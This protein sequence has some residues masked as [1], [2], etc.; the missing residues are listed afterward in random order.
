M[1]E[2]LTDFQEKKN[3]CTGPKT[4][5][6]RVKKLI[7]KKRIKGQK[8]IRSL[9]RPKKNE[10]L[11]FT[12]DFND[13]CAQGGIDVDSQQLQLAIALSKSLQQSDQAETVDFPTNLTSQERTNRIRRTLQEY[14]FKIPQAKIKLET[15][16]RVK[17]YRKPFK[18]LQISEEERIQKICNKYSQVLLEN[19]DKSYENETNCCNINNK[20]YHI[21]TNIT[22]EYI[23]TNELYKT[24]IFDEISVSK[25]NLLRDWSDIPGRPVSPNLVEDYVISMQDI[26]CSQNEL[27][28]ILSGRLFAAKNILKTK[29]NSYLNTND[30]VNNIPEINITYENTKLTDKGLNELESNQGNLSTMVH[31]QNRSNSPD[32]FDDDP[33]IINHS[34]SENQD[35][36]KESTKTSDVSILNLTPTVTNKEVSSQSLDNI[37]KRKSNDFMDLTECVPIISNCKTKL[38]ETI[39]EIELAHNSM[40]FTKCVNPISQESNI[41]K[42]QIINFFSIQECVTLDEDSISN[43][44]A[45]VSGKVLDYSSDDTIIL[46]DDFID[47]TQNCGPKVLV[48]D[49]LKDDMEIMD[50]TQSSNS[51]E[52]PAVNI[53]GT[54]RLSPDD[55]IILPYGSDAMPQT[56]FKKLN[57]DVIEVNDLDISDD[58]LTEINSKAHNEP[59]INH[60]SQHL[61]EDFVAD[62]SFRSENIENAQ[63][64]GIN[65]DLTQSSHSTIDDYHENSNNNVFENLQINDYDSLGKKGDISIDYDEIAV[66]QVENIS[67]TDDESNIQSKETNFSQSPNNMNNSKNDIVSGN[68]SDFKLC[69][70]ELNYSLYK[71]KVDDDFDDISTVNDNNEVPNNQ[72]SNNISCYNNYTINRSLSESDLP[73]VNINDMTK[74]VDK[75]FNITLSKS[76]CSTPIKATITN[77]KISIKT[78][79]N[80]EYV[81][82]LGEVT[83]MLDYEAMS[84]PERNKELEKYGLK[85]FKRK[86]AIQL[87][88]HLYNQTHPVIEQC[89]E[90]VPF[91]KFKPNSPEE[92]SLEKNNIALNKENIYSET[93][94][95]PD[96]KNIECCPDD[97]IFQKREKAK[98]HSCPVPLHIAFHNY[99]SCRRH[100]REA[101]LRYEPINIDVIHK[102]LVSYGYKY[103]PKDLLKFLD[104]KCITVK[105]ADNKARNSK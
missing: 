60:N 31:E 11:T 81:V 9:I 88:T 25:G 91:K 48:E 93:K 28:I 58:I 84:S 100:L 76:A 80:S 41:N 67:S 82:K 104:R 19:P 71:S 105:T 95:I 99:V 97:W 56:N 26:Q 18:L 101:I 1:D 74:Y 27:D 29:L 40:E 85:P 64:N 86:R 103:N 10:L 90:D 47:L 24:E 57:K 8:D 37:T 33:S 32:I 94:T 6:P 39:N 63:E 7:S 55:T 92:N 102:D 15:F 12:K 17:K 13:V 68:I 22:Y 78:P 66:D 83:P 45:A 54:Q 50:L 70:R 38:L 46:K 35:A 98:V 42:E 73:N 79:T 62:Q 72:K 30:Q 59:T 44:H 49:S 87:L 23:K 77:D 4:K 51:N 2:S 21:A 43:R 3:I 36:K 20:L 89:T 65:I 53:P 52:L 69:D 16:K 96:I 14:G 5:K 61:D 75:Q 34:I